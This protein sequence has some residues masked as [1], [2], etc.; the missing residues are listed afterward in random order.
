M[1]I[2][3]WSEFK[4]QVRAQ[5]DIVALIG[6]TRTVTQ[7]GRQFVALCP[8]HDDH[9]PSL[10]IDRERQTYRCWVCNEGGDAFSYLMK[11]EGLDFRATLEQLAL[12]AGLEMP[13]SAERSGQRKGTDR[14]T[15]FAA[16]DWASQKYHECLLSDPAAEPA[17][18]YLLDRGFCEE[19]WSD[20]QLGFHPGGWDWLLKLARGKFT[21][22][23]LEEA[24][25]IS[26]RNQG[27][28][29]F[30][31]FRSRIMFPIR[32]DRGQPIAFGGRVLPGS[33][34]EQYGKY[35]NSKESAYFNKSRQ[36]YG[37]DHAK[38]AMRDRDEVLVVEGYTDCI[39]LHQVGIPNVVATLGTA[40]THE[41]VQLIRRFCQKVILIF[42]GDTAGQNAAQ[43][44]LPRLLSHEIDLRLLALPEG[45]DPPEYLEKHG[46]QEFQTLL[47]NAEDAWDFKL[48]NLAAKYSDDSVFSREQ[49]TSEMLELLAVAPGLSGTKREDMLL[50]RLAL[51]VGLRGSQE[52]KLRSE[53]AKL[54]A[55]GPQV[56][57]PSSRSPEVEPPVDFLPQ[58]ETVSRVHRRDQADGLLNP[59][60]DRYTL[61]ERDLLEIVFMMPDCITEILDREVPGKLRHPLVSEIVAECARLSQ[62]N[63]YSGTDALLAATEDPELKRLILAI[64]AQAEE[65]KIA[66]KLDETAVNSEGKRQPL[67]LNQVISQLEW[68]H[69]ESHHRASTRTVALNRQE[70]TAVDDR[71]RQLLQ[72]A[73]QF[74]QQRVTRNT[75][76]SQ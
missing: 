19:I 25:L 13:K 61:L 10:T 53:L 46:L 75:A 48:R 57:K 66:E 72:D 35:Q 64:A 40:L 41:H 59:K 4:E 76:S 18:D 14:A 5:T 34:D 30:D 65:K 55:K 60:L 67:Y 47:Q 3:T 7:K 43:R 33:Q 17:R 39:A 51:R 68:E 15:I 16:L 37:L 50:N 24:R 9:S 45:M 2:D 70:P 54:R 62:R 27:D 32:N 38:Q 6:E 52:Q 73:A 22:Q 63:Q 12:R 69:R 11:L 8:F 58:E 44:A 23:Q 1:Q 49:L 74:H 29:F 20:F 36:L 71:M 26:R 21:P 28:G 42:D 31:L 56:A